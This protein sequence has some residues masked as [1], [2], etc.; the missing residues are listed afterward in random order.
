MSDKPNTNIDN[1]QPSSGRAMMDSAAAHVREG[2][3][4][5]KGDSHDTAAA[6]K[7]KK[8]EF[9]FQEDLMV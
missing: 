1:Q 7:D 3:A 6:A 2:I 9:S 8:G 5:I 4:H